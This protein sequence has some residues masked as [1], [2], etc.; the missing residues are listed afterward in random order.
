MSQDIRTPIKLE[1]SETTSNYNRL[2]LNI[3]NTTDYL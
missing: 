1:D 3:A 2:E